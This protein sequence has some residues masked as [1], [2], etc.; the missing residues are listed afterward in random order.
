MSEVLSKVK[1]T[2]KAHPNYK[3][4]PTPEGETRFQYVFGSPT[5]SNRE[6]MLAIMVFRYSSNELRSLAG[7]A[8]FTRRGV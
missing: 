8:S 7:K 4:G 2:A 1:K 6:I 5:D 3:K